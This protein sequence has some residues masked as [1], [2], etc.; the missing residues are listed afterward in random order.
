MLACI[1]MLLHHTTF[2]DSEK[3][4]YI[5]FLM[6]VNNLFQPSNVNILCY[7][8]RLMPTVYCFYYIF[9]VSEAKQNPISYLNRNEFVESLNKI[10]FKDHKQASFF[11]GG[12]GRGVDI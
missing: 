1:N 10:S 5:S 11:F 9:A 2:L 12:W 4:K 6:P 8:M 3:H 7:H